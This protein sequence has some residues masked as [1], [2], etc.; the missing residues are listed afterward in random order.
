[1]SAH[2]ANQLTAIETVFEGHRFR[3]R[4]EARWAVLFSQLRLSGDCSFGSLVAT[5]LMRVSRDGDAR[6]SIGFVNPLTNDYTQWMAET[7]T[8]AAFARRRG[9]SR[10][11]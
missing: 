8:M 4:A 9:V 5:K 11:A 6:L 1:M 2:G 7:I 3:S 10:A